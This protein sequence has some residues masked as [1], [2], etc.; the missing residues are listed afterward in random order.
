NIESKISF[1][2]SPALTEA[3]EH[4]DRGELP[5]A[6]R[7]LQ[8]HL[9]RFPNDVEAM[10]VLV[11]VYQRGENYDAVNQTYARVIRQHLAQGDKEAALYATTA[12]CHR[13]LKMPSIRNCR[14]ATG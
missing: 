13:F 1:E 11:Q 6:E 10:M 3:F 8:S 5:M 12:Y 14:C 4:L 7:K 9:Y 2:A